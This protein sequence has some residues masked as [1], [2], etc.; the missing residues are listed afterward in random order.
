MA[1][2]RRLALAV[3]LSLPLSGCG[4]NWTKLRGDG[5][6]DSLSGEGKN[7]R[8]SESAGTPLGTSQKALEIEQNLGYR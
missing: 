2:L 4:W 7:L 5:L 8:Q 3:L 1:K 6:D